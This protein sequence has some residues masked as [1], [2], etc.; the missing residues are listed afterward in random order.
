[1]RAGIVHRL[2]TALAV[3]ALMAVAVYVLGTIG[4]TRLPQTPVPGPQVAVGA[5]SDAP[6]VL[7]ADTTPEDV[8]EA[9]RASGFTGVQGDGCECLYLPIG[10]Q[11]RSTDPGEPG[12][13]VVE[14]TTEI[15][16][17]LDYVSV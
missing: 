9:F 17:Y 11:A 15:I 4:A 2:L 10:S 13:W 1:M 14:S 5:S 6:L 8:W 12:T 3:G 7:D 16:L